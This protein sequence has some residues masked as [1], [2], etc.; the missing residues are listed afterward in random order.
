MSVI[1][2]IARGDTVT[3]EKEDLRRFFPNS[4]LTSALDLDPTVEQI[5]ITNPSITLQV[6]DTIRYVTQYHTLS[7]SL[8]PK[9]EQE[10]K[11]FTLSAGYLGSNLLA[12]IVDS[13]KIHDIIRAGEAD[14]FS[15]FR[16]QNYHGSY[17]EEAIKLVQLGIVD[18]IIRRRQAI[19]FHMS[20]FD[21]EQ[22]VQYNQPKIL[23]RLL[24]YPNRQ[25]STQYFRTQ[26]WAQEYIMDRLRSG[27][28]TD[29]IWKHVYD[30]LV[31]KLHPNARGE[32]SVNISIPLIL[33]I[34]K[35]NPEIIKILL[36]D[37]EIHS[38]YIPEAVKLRLQEKFNIIINQ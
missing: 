19:G 22:A 6:L 34:E 33:A 20:Q 18:V 37:S 11:E 3:V 21:L 29:T 14:V 26:Y 31:R 28:M 25:G 32:F 9:T 1:L 27:V 4:L 8:E 5:Q 38:S 2:Q 30:D 23:E 17:L 13:N 16:D 10:K 24:Q 15:L 12:A 7:A 36:A 35:G